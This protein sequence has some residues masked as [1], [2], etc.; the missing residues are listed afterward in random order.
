MRRNELMAC[1]TTAAEAQA[2]A[3]HICQLAQAALRAERAKI[4]RPVSEPLIRQQNSRYF[5]LSVS[6]K[7]LE[8][9][10]PLGPLRSRYLRW[11]TVADVRD[12]IPILRLDGT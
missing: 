3:F 2:S 6:K 10:S 5:L 9:A 12:L 8:T 11:L 7:V 1:V 4:A